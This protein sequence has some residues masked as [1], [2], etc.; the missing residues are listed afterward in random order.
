LASFQQLSNW[1]L[2]LLQC[3]SHRGQISADANQTDNCCA[4]SGCSTAT[5]GSPSCNATQACIRVHHN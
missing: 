4:F 3:I 1:R 5:G 2:T